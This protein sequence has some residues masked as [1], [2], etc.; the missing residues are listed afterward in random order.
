MF[1]IKKENIDLKY[2]LLLIVIAY[3]FSIAIRMIWV[4]QF[5]G[6][7]SFYW[8]NQLMIN[9][10]D[11]YIWGSS[12]LHELTNEF[13]NN[14]RIVDM[15]KYGTVFFT[16]LAV[17]ILP[18]SLDTIMLYMP[19]VI[20]SLVVIPII[21]IARLYNLTLWGFF[22][23]LIG[24]I[25]WSYYNRTMIGYYDTDMFSAMAPMVILYFLIKTIEDESLNNALFSSLSI[26]VYPF[27][28]D[29]GLSIVYAI[30]LLYMAYMIAF[31]KKEYF[32]YQSII[33][34]SVALMGIAWFIKLAI[35]FG[36]Y[37]LFKNREFPL[38]QLIIVSIIS[39]IVFLISGNVVSIIL[40]K[41]IGYTVRG[42]ENEG[43][44]FF[45]VAQTV[46]EAGKIPFEVMAN[47]ISGSSLGVIISL[48]GYGLL[49]L[50][51]RPFILALPLI[52]IGVF[53]LFGGLRFTVYAVPVAAMSSVYLFYV[54]ASFTQSNIRR[55]ALV[56]TLTAFML[57]PNIKHIVEYKVP[58]VFNKSEVQILDKLKSVSSTKDYTI[59]WW[60]YGYPLW[61]YTNTNT[62]IDGGKHNHDNF[63]VSQI[64]TADS[65]RQ[66]AN[67]ARLSIETYV[68][69]EYKIVADEIFKN[70]MQE[71]IN[72][73]IMLDELM[74]SDFKLP[75]KTR[76]IYLYLPNRMLNIL[77]TVSLFSNL[78]LMTGEAKERP[79]FFISRNF[80]DT[81]T[82]I[83]LGSGL[84]ILKNQG[85]IEIGKNLVSINN[86]VVT[87]YDNKGK[88]TK[89]IQKLNPNSNINV[90]Y[91]KNYNQFLVLDKKMYNSLFI[92][93]FVLEE[94]DGS[95][96]EPVILNPL[97]KVYKLKV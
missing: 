48:I 25:A 49:V 37:F 91:M 62:L 68:S 63:I 96:F 64:L 45:Q 90:I 55:Y 50:K 40:A 29:A 13:E 71:Q 12:A 32:T 66:A 94:Y 19:A 80:K 95:F 2:A 54:L 89:N 51:H 61:Y 30:G 56:I 8:N 38:K 17:K 33:L 34:I 21:L 86:F 78:D 24:S 83:N 82:T 67:L 47:R 31:H 77:P 6:A 69:S 9:T 23:A 52:G 97:A 36:L 35:I 73:N 11:G 4:Y 79:L 27:L 28:Y 10:N 59:A 7:D 75:Q 70:K 88:F 72:P 26:L 92:Q 41:I 93:L 16:Y 74:L 15:F 81:G 1:D 18:F 76:D 65:Q 5:S 53:S 22:A 39:V 14:S 85:K 58:T 44:K 57:Y 42:N 46:R 43:L 3:T 60:D 84:T 87:A 20:S